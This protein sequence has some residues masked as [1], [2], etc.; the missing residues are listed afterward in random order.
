MRSRIY[1]FCSRK[2]TS[3]T[4]ATG[5]GQHSEQV[6]ASLT[7]GRRGVVSQLVPGNLGGASEI[8]VTL[9]GIRNGVVAVQRRSAGGRLVVAGRGARA[10]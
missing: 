7:R 10:R 4:I 9:D 2:K 8:R 3:T 6:L 1:L 5:P